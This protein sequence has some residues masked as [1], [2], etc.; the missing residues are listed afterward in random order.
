MSPK[1]CHP[2]AK[3][4]LS[5]ARGW[6]PPNTAS[7]PLYVRTKQMLSIPKRKSMSEHKSPGL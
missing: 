4:V 5:F 1:M 6:Y 3:L 2:K 7:F